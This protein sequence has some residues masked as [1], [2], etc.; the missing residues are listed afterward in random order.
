MDIN[1]FIKQVEDTIEDIEPN[2]IKP[3]A[4]FKS[5]EQ[6]DSLAMLS[7]LAKLDSEYNV[8]LTAKDLNGCATVTDLFELVKSR[9]E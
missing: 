4:D 1:S 9:M 8:E 7:L 2:S 6:W 3:D 5:L